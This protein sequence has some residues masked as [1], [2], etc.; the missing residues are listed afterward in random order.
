[1]NKFK[2]IST[3]F[4]TTLLLGTFSPLGATSTTVSAANN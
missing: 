1:M 3:L 2:K 4:V